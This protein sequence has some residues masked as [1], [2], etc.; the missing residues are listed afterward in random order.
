MSWLE[1]EG[2]KKT[3]TWPEYEKNERKGARASKKA[4]GI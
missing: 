2:M 1:L 4:K 3:Q